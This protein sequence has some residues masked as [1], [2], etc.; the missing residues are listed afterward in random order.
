MD[1]EVDINERDALIQ[2]TVT[3]LIIDRIM[4]ETEEIHY[5]K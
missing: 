2:N 5:F 3:S 1:K 4:G